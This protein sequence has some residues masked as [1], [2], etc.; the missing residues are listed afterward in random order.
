MRKD[1]PGVRD[2]DVV[3]GSVL[4]AEAREAYAEDH[5]G[6]WGWGWV[7]GVRRRWWFGGNFLD[8]GFAGRVVRT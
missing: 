5:A 6:F 7:D 4:L 1:E 3:K 8:R 2:D